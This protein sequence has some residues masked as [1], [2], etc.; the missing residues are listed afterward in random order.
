MSTTYTD[1]D[2]ANLTEAERAALNDPDAGGDGTEGDAASDENDTTTTEGEGDA[3]G[4]QGE[5]G[6]DVDVGAAGGDGAAA[7]V[8]D[9]RA[10]AP[11]A[12]EPAAAPSAPAQSAPILVAQAPEDAEARLAEIAT[13]KSELDQK[14]D[15]GDITTAYYRKEMDALNKQERAIEFAQQEAALA[16]KIERQRQQNEWDGHCKVFFDQHKEYTGEANKERFDYLNRAVIALANM[17]RHANITGPELLA[18]AHKI[19]QIEY[20]EDAAPAPAPAPSPAPQAKTIKP[21]EKNVPPSLHAVP[22]A[23]PSDTSGGKW[24]ALD[25]LPPEQLED[26]LMKL[27]D[28][29]RSAYLAAR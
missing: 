12:D 24:A 17:P 1:E 9:G 7:P 4:D 27:S 19:T 29:D 15:D 21:V 5:G 8:D 10:A 2:L 28:S 26:A 14:F 25:R 23:E 20:D 13:K 18:K 11:A 22:A 6:N 3:T 16:E